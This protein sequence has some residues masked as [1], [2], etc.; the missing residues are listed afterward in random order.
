MSL[1]SHPLCAVDIPAMSFVRFNPVMITVGDPLTAECV[2][3]TTLSDARANIAWLSPRAITIASGDGIAFE[4]RN[5]QL[6]AS[7]PIDFSS[8]TATDF[9]QYA[10][11]AMITSPSS[12]GTQI[13]I[14]RTVEIPTTST[15]Q[16]VHA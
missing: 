4:E 16:Y 13:N 9:G 2:V 10:C 15:M 7:L 6:E 11:V 5:G 3:R 8:F 1:L 12:P 14:S